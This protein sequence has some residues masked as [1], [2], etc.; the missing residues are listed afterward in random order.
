M[1]PFW[2]GAMLLATVDVTLIIL[3]VLVGLKAELSV[4]FDVGKNSRIPA[5]VPR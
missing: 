2:T 5:C 1:S 3:Y 4:E